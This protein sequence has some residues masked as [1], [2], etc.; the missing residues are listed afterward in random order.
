VLSVY[1]F[2]NMTLTRPSNYCLRGNVTVVN[3]Q[4][5]E[6]IDYIRNAFKNNMHN[7]DW[8]DEETR[9]VAFKKVNSVHCC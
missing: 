2:Y 9:E 5:E 6:M 4:A 3:I 7:L 1:A 8:I